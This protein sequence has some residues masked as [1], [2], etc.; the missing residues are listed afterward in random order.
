MGEEGADDSRD[1]K[2]SEEKKKK[3]YGDKSCER[4]DIIP[5]LHKLQAGR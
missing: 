5:Y 1:K 2:K 3:S 4:G